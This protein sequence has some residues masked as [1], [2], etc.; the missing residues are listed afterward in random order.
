MCEDIILSRVNTQMSVSLL[1]LGAAVLSICVI[2][3]T[4]HLAEESRC[5]AAL[6]TQELLASAPVRGGCNYWGHCAL[7][8]VGMV[9]SDP[10]PLEHSTS[11]I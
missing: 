11:A 1:P 7:G 6:N 8:R 10:F 9:F 4:E 5:P 2:T 3:H